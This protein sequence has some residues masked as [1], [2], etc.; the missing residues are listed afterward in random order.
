MFT[1]CVQSPCLTRSKRSQPIPRKSR[2]R[3][4]RSE[5]SFIFMQSLIWAVLSRL[6]IWML[7]SIYIVNIS[8]S[9]Y[10][11]FSSTSLLENMTLNLYGLVSAM[12]DFN[13]IPGGLESERH[14]VTF[15]NVVL[16]IYI[17]SYQELC[18]RTMRCSF[19]NLPTCKMQ[20]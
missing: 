1:A 13:I 14:F 17:S 15:S 7:V 5:V 18:L 8:S 20:N 3:M 9:R 6:G 16:D 10:L 12:R 2:R 19:G 11:M 4:A